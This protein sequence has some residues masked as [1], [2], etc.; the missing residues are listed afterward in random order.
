MRST[1]VA[2]LANTTPLRGIQVGGSGALRGPDGL[3]A[4]P[5]GAVWLGSHAH[6]LDPYVFF[7]LLRHLPRSLRSTGPQQVLPV[8]IA[9]ASTNRWDWFLEELL[10]ASY[11]AQVTLREQRPDETAEGALR[12]REAN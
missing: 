11:F 9:R 12:R 5:A 7:S 6:R 2:R 4:F 10:F 1:T 8:V 3:L